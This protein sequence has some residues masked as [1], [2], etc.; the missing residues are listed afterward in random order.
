M[1]SIHVSVLSWCAPL[2][3]AAACS[4]SGTGT[5]NTPDAGG[6]GSASGAGSGS[7]SGAESGAGEAGSG[8]ATSGGQ[9]SDAST[10]DVATSGEDAGGGAPDSGDDVSTVADAEPIDAPA[11]APVGNG[12]LVLSSSAFM[13]NGTIDPMYQC[14]MPNLSPPLSWTPGPAGTQSYAVTLVHPT[15]AFH[16]VLWD[17]PATTTSLAAGVARMA[18]LPDGSMQTTPNLDGSTWAGY[19]G[20][21]PMS[22]NQ[23]Y[24]YTVYAVSA[25]P[26][27]GVTSKSTGAAV[28]TAIQAHKLASSSLTVIASK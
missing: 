15:A 11:E 20:P 5:Q 22:A 6:S 8:G 1:R 10:M 17:I 9:G 2:V 3:L 16:W 4:S 12:M 21:C 26:L 19:T 24:I 25:K 13:N 18:M 28:N 27:P 7:T 23:S 14:G